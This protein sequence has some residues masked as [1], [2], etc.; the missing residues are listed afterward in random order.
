MIIM[1]FTLTNSP[2]NYIVNKV[3]VKLLS[4]VVKLAAKFFFLVVTIKK[5][6]LELSLERVSVNGRL[7]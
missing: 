4:L 1:R 5:M 6:S 7:K 2:A 3:A